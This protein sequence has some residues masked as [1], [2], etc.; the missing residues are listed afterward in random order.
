MNIFILKN[1]LKIIKKYLY[2]VLHS[3]IF[4]MYICITYINVIDGTLKFLH[5]E[6]INESIKIWSLTD[7]IYIFIIMHR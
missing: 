7:R 2:Y 6:N 3:T 4:C 5:H 1:I